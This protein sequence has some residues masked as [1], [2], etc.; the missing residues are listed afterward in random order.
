MPRTMPTSDNT[1][2][3]QT[4]FPTKKTGTDLSGICPIGWELSGLW[5]LQVGG[6]RGLTVFVDSHRFKI[7]YEGEAENV[8]FCCLCTPPVLHNFRFNHHTISNI[9]IISGNWWRPTC[10]AYLQNRKVVLQR[11]EI[12][13]IVSSNGKQICPPS[14]KQNASPLQAIWKAIFSF[15]RRDYNI[16]YVKGP[17]TMRCCSRH[18]ATRSTNKYSK[19]IK[20]IRII[21]N[22][23]TT[24]P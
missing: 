6:L 18:Y 2:S 3:I 17:F 9:Y 4:A 13:F 12:G 7:H 5:I 15:S 20:I 21:L 11:K 23:T 10:V 8:S 16:T 14:P 19:A 22:L 1:H 24:V